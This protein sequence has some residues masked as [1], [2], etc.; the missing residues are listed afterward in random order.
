MI[1]MTS[2]YTISSGAVFEVT[3]R[4]TAEECATF[5]GTYKGMSAIAS[6]TALVF[7]IDGMLRFVNASAI[8]CMDQVEAAPETEQTAKKADPGN[9]FYG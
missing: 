1:I 6:D 8:V 2:D 3:W 9:I 5:T 7:K 4:R